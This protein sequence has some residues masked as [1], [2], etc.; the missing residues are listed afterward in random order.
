ML[1]AGLGNRNI[2]ADS[3]GPKV[4]DYVLSTRHIIEELKESSGFDSLFPVASIE[5]GVLG[6][7][8]IETAE[9]I[10]GVAD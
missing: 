8:G 1:V 6:E 4:G 10:K 5:T 2:T 3:L 9:I 7:T